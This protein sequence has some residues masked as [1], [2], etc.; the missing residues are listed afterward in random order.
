LK[1]KLPAGYLRPVIGRN[2]LW[3]RGLSKLCSLE[4]IASWNWEDEFAT[5]LPV[6][7]TAKSRKRAKKIR[8]EMGLQLEDWFVCVHVR[9]GGYYPIEKEG[10][11]KKAR[12]ASPH[13]YLKAIKLITE[14]GGWVIRMGD[15]SMTPLPQME[16]VI[17]YPFTKYK[18]CL[19][20]IYFIKEC[21]FYIGVSSGVFDVANLFQ[22]PILLT[23]SAATIP[24]PPYR[25]GDRSIFKHVKMKRLKR[26]LSIQERIQLFSERK[27]EHDEYGLSENTPD[28]IKDL[29]E[30]YLDDPTAKDSTDLQRKWAIESKRVLLNKHKYLSYNTELGPITMQ[31]ATAIDHVAAGIVGKKFIEQNY[32]YSSMN[33][34]M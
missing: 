1:K 7:L 32:Y 17:D 6:D 18:S 19:M 23:N 20:D 8:M 28:E 13:N 3:N 9:E 15:A 26:F 25:K 33:S 4:E 31:R 22:K 12:N 11:A 14:R 30:E 10:F 16:K 5:H 24:S 2:E 34:P 27:I 29:V 21:R